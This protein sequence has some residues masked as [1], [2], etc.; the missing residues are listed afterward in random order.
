MAF[1][2]CAFSSHRTSVRPPFLGPPSQHSAPDDHHSWAR[3]V[4][5]VPILLFLFISARE[6]KQVLYHHTGNLL[7]YFF[8]L[9]IYSDTLLLFIPGIACSPLNKPSCVGPVHPPPTPRVYP[10]SMTMWPAPL[11]RLSRASLAPLSRTSFTNLRTLPSGHTV[12]IIG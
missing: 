11:S 8:Y 2:A 9:F 5:I 10:N 1:L 3:P 6:K 7:F 4:S 12:A